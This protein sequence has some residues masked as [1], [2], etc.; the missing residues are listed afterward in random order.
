MHSVGI[1]MWK[2]NV[3]LAKMFL[4]PL[5]KFPRWTM[6]QPVKLLLGSGAKMEF[7]R[8]KDFLRSLQYY[9]MPIFF[10]V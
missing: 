1:Y 2:P 9:D 6:I 4:M 10:L 8:V 5:E 3:R 7:V